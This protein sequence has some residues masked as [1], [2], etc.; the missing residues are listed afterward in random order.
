[1]QARGRSSPRLATL[2]A[3]LPHGL[4][5][6]V[7]CEQLEAR[8]EVPSPWH[9][10]PAMGRPTFTVRLAGHRRPSRYGDVDPLRGYCAR[11]G[12]T[13]S[14][15]RVPGWPEAGAGSRRAA[16]AAARVLMV[17]ARQAPRGCADR[18]RQRAAKPG[19]GIW[20][21]PG[22]LGVTD[23]RLRLPRQL[24]LFGFL[25]V[26]LGQVIYVSELLPYL[27]IDH[28]VEA[29]NSVAP[30]V[31][32]LLAWAW[33]SSLGSLR[34]QL[35]GMRRRPLTV[36]ALAYAVLAAGQDALAL[37]ADASATPPVVVAFW[38]SFV[39]S[40]L[41]AAGFRKAAGVFPSR[42]GSASR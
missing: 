24:I 28:G 17:V 21:G 42:P 27:R 12:T 14:M 30:T 2:Q 20:D 11:P 34:V 13:T 35:S 3:G 9:P 1:M 8:G 37:Q 41:A 15:S 33:W 31:S 38:L 36:F 19:T 5:P 4:A 23:E 32:A 10:E 26:L 18:P 25:T 40:G 7:Q 16:E 39:G 29:S 22:S 6:V